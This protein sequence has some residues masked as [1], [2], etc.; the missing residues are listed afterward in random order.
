ME[1]MYR[2]A[3]VLLVMA[4]CGANADQISFD[5]SEGLGDDLG[6]CD[7][8]YYDNSHGDTPSL[9]LTCFG[10]IDVSFFLDPRVMDTEQGVTLI[11]EPDAIGSFG[12][13]GFGRFHSLGAERRADHN[14][15]RSLD[16]VSIRWA[17]Q[18]AC[19]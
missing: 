12:G 9:Q 16:G 1:R 10:D 8:Q 14:I 18:E 11:F 6:D 4:A 19:D 13:A 3:V 5:S 2:S 7:C 15:V 17:E